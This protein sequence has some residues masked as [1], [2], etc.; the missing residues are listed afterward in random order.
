MGCI[1]KYKG[2]SI[3]EEQF[4]QYLNKQI[5]IN[6]LFNENETLANAV[7]EALGFNQLITSNDRIV[8]GHPGIGKTFLKESGRTDVIDFDS[9]YKIKINEKFN[10]P[11]GFKARNDFQK[12]NKEEYQK[13]VRELW[14]EAKQE[15][16]KTGKQLFASDMI[17]LREFAND[18]DKVI[19]M[20]KETFINRAK[21][22]NDYTPG[23]EG[24]EGWKNSL[25]K[26][27]AKIDKSKVFST[28]KYL[29]ELFI[30]PQQKQQAQQLYSQHLDTVFPDS[31]VKDIVRH[32]TDNKFWEGVLPNGKD[33]KSKRGI[34][35]NAT[36]GNEG[37][38]TTASY[39]IKAII[40][41]TNPVIKD[42]DNDY[43]GQNTNELYPNNDGV[44]GYIENP[45]QIGE[46][47][48]S[49]PE[50]IHILGSKQDVEGF[51]KF[52]DSGKQIEKSLS[53]QSK[54]LNLINE[55]KIT[56]FCK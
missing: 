28:D 11:K 20:S 2:Q 18:F 23:L 33:F 51:K 25:D 24:T 45:T 27:I 43:G 35:F 50:Q 17:L 4:L 30:T 22:R 46:Y 7:Y 53:L 40:N 38:F 6:N 39:K 49:K 47:I 21:Q 44:I 29:S 37:G 8:F 41:L 55:G 52:V 10:L 3:P 19:T 36:S 5:A 16:N 42:M 15:A 26:E 14:N 31:K 56:K 1:I 34:Y 32:D 54:I 13:A 12:S 48:V 9:D